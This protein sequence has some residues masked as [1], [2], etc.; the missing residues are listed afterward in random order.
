M[1]YL[2][3]DKQLKSRSLE[4]ELIMDPFCVDAGWGEAV[5]KNT[6]LKVPMIIFS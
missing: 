2:G 3:L 5:S 1:R 6:S 4:A